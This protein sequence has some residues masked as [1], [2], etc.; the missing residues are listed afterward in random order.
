MARDREGLRSFEFLMPLQPMFESASSQIVN[1]DLTPSFDTVVSMMI[2]EETWMR[3]P[4]TAL[5]SP[6]ATVLAAH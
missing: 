4:A 3:S 1:R 5:P 6:P 2:A